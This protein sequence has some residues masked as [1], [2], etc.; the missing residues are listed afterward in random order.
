MSPDQRQALRAIVEPA[1][2]LLNRVEAEETLEDIRFAAGAGTSATRNVRRLHLNMTGDA[3]AER[4]NT[5][6]GIVLDGISLSAL[7]AENAEFIPH[8]VDLKT[9][10]SGVRIGPLMAAAARCD[11]AGNGSRRASG[12]GDD[13]AGRSAGPDQ[14][15]GLSFDSGPLQI[16]GS[17]KDVPRPDGQLGADIHMAASGMNTLLAQTQSHP[18]LHRSCQWCSWQRASVAR[19]ATA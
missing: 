19:M 18:N 8:R 14:H 2:G 9:N 10:L 13:V 3:L 17:A 1:G 7:P 5:Q 11:R 6:L 16:T 4:L 12:A 15:R